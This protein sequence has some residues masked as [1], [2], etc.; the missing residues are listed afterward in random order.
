MLT[1]SI[2]FG[3]ALVATMTALT[4][5]VALA[6][7]GTA[8]AAS[9][10]STR[11]PDVQD[12]FTTPDVRWSSGGKLETTLRASYGD[13]VLNGQRYRTLNYEGSVPGP[14]LAVCP[15]DTLIVH[16][17]N[18]LGDTPKGWMGDVP[19]MPDM[20]QAAGQLTNLH[21]HGMHVSPNGHSDNVFVSKK[22][23]EEFTYTY[24]IP[25][26]QPPGM[27]WYHPHRHGYTDTQVYAGMY[28]VL[29]VRGGLDV[30]PALAKVPTRTLAISSLQLGADHAVVPD[31][32]ATTTQN[33]VNGT[34]MP[35]ITV[36]PGELQRWRILNAGPDSVLHLGLTNGDF[37][38]LAN[39]GNTLQR[40]AHQK[41]LLVS[42]G[43]RIE[44]LVRGGP[45]GD[46]TLEALAFN[47]FQGGTSTD[48]P[49][50]T[51]HSAAGAART[52][53]RLQR[54]ALTSKQEDLR[55]EK[56]S[57][58]HRLVYTE[59]NLANGNTNFLINGKMFDPKRVDAVMHL[60]KVS[61]WTMVNHTTEWHTFHIHLNYFQIVKVTNGNVANVS[62]G[63]V[64]DVPRGAIERKDTVLLP[65]GGSVVMRTKPTDYTGKF[66]FHCHMLFH[67]DHG[68]MGVVE[69][70][71]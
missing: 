52:P 61:Q 37:T 25:T 21:L 41:T 5:M 27:Y 71:K 42:P 68:M 36:H 44:V 24:R 48:T 40:A 58:R 2:R 29:W 39:D 7:P 66:V 30:D 56:V 38:V 67:E 31:A 18:D 47:Q 9:A 20:D 4:A 10:C 65:P 50:A 34:V 6:G 12:G 45:V 64:E 26:D 35:T 59:Q 23:G 16:M 63:S 22:P 28:G 11:H 53:T 69:V 8:G 54:A 19:I 17:K 51:V 15:G 13:V 3:A 70:R 32:A 46:S 62:T 60:G 57:D 55:T 43:A 1:R 33:F 14:T 49:L